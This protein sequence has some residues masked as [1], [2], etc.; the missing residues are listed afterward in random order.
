V[1]VLLQ[2]CLDD[3]DVPRIYA[4]VNTFAAMQSI[5]N[6]TARIRI[7]DRKRVTRAIE[8]MEDGIDFVRLLDSLTALS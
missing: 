6:H 4:P 5:S 8:L 1:V 7:E 3:V 2:E